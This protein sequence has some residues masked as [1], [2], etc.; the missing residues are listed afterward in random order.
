MTQKSRAELVLFCMTL[1]WGSTFVLGKIVL[2]EMPPLQMIAIRFVFSTVVIFL[3]AF[4]SIF[5]LRLDQLR[6]GFFLGLFLFLGFVPQTIGLT[7]TSASKSAFIT[8]MMVV[9]VPLLQ[10][11][12]ERKPPK[13]G[14]LAGVVCVVAGLWFLTS[15]AG[16]SFNLGDGLSL[17]CAALFGV[18]IVYLD[19]ISNDMS[20][21]QLTFIQVSTN[22]ILS[23]IAM[24]FFESA[25]LHLSWTGG[26]TL[27]YLAVFATLLTTFMQTRFQKFTTPTRAVIIFTIEPVFASLI[28][29]LVLGEQLGVLGILGGALIIAGVLVSELS[30][31]IPMLNRSLGATDS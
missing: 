25:P 16:S 24:V 9:F 30:E 15:P 12:I 20:P 27:V 4:R 3:A 26:A 11:I 28:A 10:I 1:I 7:I 2:R 31:G 6:K 17:V 5:P 21:A 13:L 22:A 23:I 29:A 14:N 19:V 18:Y 8:G